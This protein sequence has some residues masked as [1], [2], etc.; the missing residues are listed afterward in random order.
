VSQLLVRPNSATTTTLKLQVA[1]ANEELE[2]DAEDLATQSGGSNVLTAKQLDGLA[3]DPDD[4]QRQLQSLA[5]ASGGMPGSAQITVDGFQ[6]PTTL[7]PKSAIKEVRI[8]P[9]MYSAE[10]QYPPY[11]GGRIEV[12]TKPGQDKFHGAAFGVIG[13]HIWNANDPLGM[14]GTPADRQREGFELSGPILENKRASFGLDLE[15]R[16][17]DEDAV[18]NATVLSSS[19]I[20]ALFNQTVATPQRLWLGNARTG[21]QLG[22]KDTLTLSFAAN[23]TS[24]TNKGVGGLTLQ[25]AGTFSSISDYDLRALNTTFISKNLL[26]SFRVGLSWKLTSQI[27]NSTVPEVQVPG[28]FIGGGPVAGTLHDAEHDLEIDDEAYLSLKQN[29]IK[30]GIQLQGYFIND[31]DPDTFN[32][33]FTFSGGPAPALDGSG[34]TILISGL[35]QYRRA[36]A[37]QLG[38]NPTTYSQTFGNPQVN[39][40]QWTIA[41]YSQDDWKVNPRMMIS[42]GLRYFFQTSPIVATSLAPRVGTAYTFGGKSKWTVHLRSGLFYTPITPNTTIETLRLD[43]TRQQNLTAYYPDYQNPFGATGNSPNIQEVRKFTGG[44]GITPSSQSQLGLEHTLFKTWSMNANVYYTASWGVL[45]SFNANAPIFTSATVGIPSGAQRPIAPNLNLFEYG[46]TGRFAGP[47]A[48]FGLN[49]FAKRFSLISGYL[50]SGFRTNAETP[51]SFP[52]STYEKTQDWARPTGS[53]KHSVF[54]ILIY[55]LPFKIAFTTNLATSTGAPYDVTT[56]SDNNGDGIFNDRPSI[57]ST[58]GIGVYSTPFGLLSTSVA[59]G[60]LRRNI[61][62]MPSTVH[63]DLSLNRSFTIKEKRGATLHQQTL[64]FDA[65]TANL[66]NHANYNAVDGI[67]GT[68]EFTKPISADLGRRIEFGARFSF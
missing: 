7:P 16:S 41:A 2:V 53:T 64:R 43:G 56:G 55:A 68:P 13:S 48:F 51:N 49:H 37:G 27:P 15:H 36:L 10:Y 47:Y 39:L 58:S 45:R 11:E 12:F 19:G 23:S 33:A 5:A 42:A 63:L 34:S 25:E 21:L 9:D 38:G 1:S 32:G 31:Y 26:H 46:R 57:V 17:I 29:T 40:H 66:L 14:S 65:R 67:V 59:N 30:A 44:T 22:G 6:G 35:E 50:Y 61:G 8:S 28:S 20:P 62:T 4:L 54:T 52:Q 18:V 24:T 3:E 60:N